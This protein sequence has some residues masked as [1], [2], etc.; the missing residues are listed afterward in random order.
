MCRKTVLLFFT[1]IS[2]FSC[3]E[4]SEILFKETDFSD[5]SGYSSY[6]LPQYRDSLLKEMPYGNQYRIAIDIDRDSS[7]ADSQL[8]ISYFNKSGKDLSEIQFRLLMNNNTHT[9]MTI[10]SVQTG[11]IPVEFRISEDNTSLII[12]LKRKLNPGK[13]ALIQI[14]YGIDFSKASNYYF[15]FARIDKRGFSIPHFYPIAAVIHD[16]LWENDPIAY[17]GDLLSADSSWFMV[18]IISDDNVVIV[19]SGKEISREIRK[20]KQKKVYV[21]GPVRDFYICGDVSFIPQVTLSGETDVISYSRNKDSSSSAK[22]AGISSSALALFNSTFGAYPYSELKIAA[23]PMSAQGVE[24]PGLFAIREELYE[25]HE[26]SVFEPTIVHEAAHQWFYAMMGN[27]QLKEPWLDEGLAQYALWLYYRENYGA[28]A[29]LNLFNSFTERWGRIDRA[30]IPI[31]KEVSFYKGKEYS[32]IIYGR[33]PLFLIEL[34]NT[35]GVERFHSFLRHLIRQYSHRQINTEDFRT[36]LI[37][38]AGSSA[39]PLFEKYFD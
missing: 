19:T 7:T 11:E 14:Q 23:M 2:L 37:H 26:G 32:A 10:D 12:P 21:A 1:L 27:N 20:G 4:K 5:L 17:G 3:A 29:A 36:E 8:N 28:S 38:F 16:G 18:E 6:I 33:A 39:D 15:N 9:P 13:T 25:D 30:E 22:A 34:R 24:F 31:N 35:I